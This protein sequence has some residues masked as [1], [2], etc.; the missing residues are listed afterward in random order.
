[1]ITFEQLAAE[2]L[3]VPVSGWDF[4]WF[5]GR[6]TTE[7]LPWSYLAEVS[8]R[9]ASAYCM[10]DMGTGGGEQLSQIAPRP[11]RTVATEA[12]PPN[13]PVAALALRARG[14]PVVQDEGAPDNQ[15]QDPR[16]GR[17]PFRDEAFDLV[18]NRHEAFQAAEVGRVLAPGGTLVTQQVDYHSHDDL[19]RLLGLP[20]PAQPSSWLALGRRQLQQAGLA[21]QTA[22]AGEERYLVHD[23]AGI[24]YYLRL[25]SWAVPEFTMDG[26]AGRLRDLHDTPAVWPAAI[27]QHRFL[28]IARKPPAR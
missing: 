27:R 12:W 10:L 2:A 22:R 5:A 7:P 11:V 17:L 21:V 4:S 28:L 20:V 23:V 18:T 14:I 1:M 9:A 19:Y 6:S 16:G 3:D 15:A 24:I 26:F 8:G 25:V 13:V